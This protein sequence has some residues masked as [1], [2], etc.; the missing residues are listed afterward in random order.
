[1]GVLK[2]VVVDAPLSEVEVHPPSSYARLVELSTE[3]AA[4]L[5]PRHEVPCPGCGDSQR[6]DAFEKHGYRYVVCD[7][8]ATLYASPR[9][10]AEDLHHYL[11]NSPAARFRQEEYRRPLERRAHEEA[12]T[13]ADW[14]QEI[15]RAHGQADDGSV[16]DL[17]TRSPEYLKALSAQRLA[18]ILAIDPLTPLP[19]DLGEVGIGQR[20]GLG[21]LAAD[22]SRIITAFDVLEHV[23]DVGQVI[24][25]AHDALAP[26]G[27]LAL[28]SRSSSGLDIQVLWQH[29]P[30]IFPA[31]HLNLLSVEGARSL[32]QG[33][34]FEILEI[35]TP[36]Q[37]DVELVERVLDE[38]P[39]IEA[40]RF[41]R[42]LLTHRDQHTKGRLQQFLQQH[43]LSSHLRIVARKQPRDAVHPAPS[44]TGDSL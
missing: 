17:H 15:L 9:P 20:Q 31:D 38:Q 4:A 26:G 8:C 2:Y 30:T 13:R 28:T 39:E 35:S 19:D 16:V 44:R 1:M 14:V 29:C 12:L 22:H 6:R 27:L 18:P 43:L 23:A 40:P 37:L 3:A 41:L 24:A 42:Y 25:D 33:V 36:G 5:E 32:L 21:E 10:S 34:G 11:H 7:R